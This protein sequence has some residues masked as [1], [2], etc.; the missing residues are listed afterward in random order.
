MGRRGTPG[1][2][3]R[4]AQAEARRLPGPAHRPPARAHAAA[5]GFRG[6]KGSPP[7]PP[8]G[9]PPPPGPAAELLRAPP[10]SPARN[11]CG[12]FSLTCLSRC[13]RWRPNTPPF[14]TRR[15][16]RRHCCRR[17]RPRP[18]PAG[19]VTRT[20]RRSFRLTGV[21]ALPNQE[22]RCLRMGG[23]WRARETLPWRSRSPRAARQ[24]HLPALVRF[25]GP[26][27]ALL[28]PRAGARRPPP[29]FPSAQRSQALKV[30]LQKRQRPTGFSTQS[31]GPGPE[32]VS[33]ALGVPR[34]LSGARPPPP[35]TFPGGSP[36]N[37]SSG[38]TRSSASS[39]SGSR[40]GAPQLPGPEV[41]RLGLAPGKPGGFGEAPTLGRRSA[42]LRAGLT[43]PQ[44]RGG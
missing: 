34:A 17:R 11:P 14:P 21:A 6:R 28:A 27:P 29:A 18:T 12:R 31:L 2:R 22:R 15:R 44:H 7:L 24:R 39:Y 26:A 3:G 8:P 9:L 10:A 4:S 32:R 42:G 40:V 25:S 43:G 16:R 41:C 35:R 33:P 36:P 20:R 1:K 13:R 37:R 30:R 38:K 19:D 5:R 23:A